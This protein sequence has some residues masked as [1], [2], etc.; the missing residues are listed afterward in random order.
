MPP[1]LVAVTRKAAMEKIRLQGH[2]D[3]ELAVQTA[4][5][6]KRPA[7]VLLHGWP[8]SHTLYAPVIDPLGTN[9]F[10]LAFDLPDVGKSHGAPPSAEKTV[11][12]D[13]VLSAAEQMDAH[14]IVVAGIDV[15]GMI[16]FA[17]A[18]D[19]GKRIRGAVVANTAIPGLDPWQ[20][21]ISDPRIW[22]FG[23]HK[24]PGLPEALVQGR[25][26]KYFDYFTDVLAGDPKAVSDEYRQGFAD[27]YVRP[28]ALKAG[29]DWYRAFDADAKHNVEPATIETP[30]HYLRG[31][32]DGRQPD[33][34]LPGLRRAG[35]RRLTSEVL[36]R[37]GEYAPIE[38]PRA[39]IR[40]VTGFVSTLS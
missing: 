10:V 35:V 39:F 19:H 30:L 34:Y 4:G 27:A 36:E 28:S 12:A 3:L 5:S 29:F 21:L 17:A 13:I 26:R 38:A 22:H 25:Q 18:R 40:A 15:G 1:F 33:D 7:L 37:C 24:V 11:L 16:A 23:F 2:R 6:A 31:D 32:A 9:F 8:H 20:A 14:D